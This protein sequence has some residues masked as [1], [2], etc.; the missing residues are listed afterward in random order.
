MLGQHLAVPTLRPIAVAVLADN[1]LSE[2]DYY[3]GDLLHTVIG[4]SDREWRGAED[5]R[6]RLVDVLRERPSP[7]EHVCDGL[8]KAVATFLNQ[9]RTADH[10]P[11]A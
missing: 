7:S 2:G 5:H 8:R 4:F 10:R 11:P 9:S 6:D 1:P 3:P